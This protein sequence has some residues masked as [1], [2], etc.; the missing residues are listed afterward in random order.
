MTN[1][2]LPITDYQSPIPDSSFA[3]PRAQFSNEIVFHAPG[4][5]RFKTS[6]YVEQDAVRFAS[7]SVT[8]TEAASTMILR[9]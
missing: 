6:E 7:V 9:L 2:Q 3:A 5:R 8:G 1:Y 4:L